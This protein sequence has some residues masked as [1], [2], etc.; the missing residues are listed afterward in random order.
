MVQF[1]FAGSDSIKNW[2]ISEQNSQEEIR[3][4]HTRIRRFFDFCDKVLENSIYIRT[5]FCAGFNRSAL[6]LFG[7]F[8]DFFLFDFPFMEGYCL[9]NIYTSENM[10]RIKT[11][12][13]SSRSDLFPTRTSGTESVPSCESSLS[14]IEYILWNELLLSTAKTMIQPWIPNTCLLLRKDVSSW[15]TGAVSIYLYAYTK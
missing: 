1:H 7:E 11:Y 14:R 13:L 2:V 12:R 10:Y 15:I 9:R 3:R 8:G 6:P 4:K 5:F